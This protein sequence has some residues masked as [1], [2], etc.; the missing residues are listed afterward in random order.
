MS[1][2]KSCLSI[3]I[4]VALTRLL[5]YNGIYNGLR[6]HQGHPVSDP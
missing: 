5:R 3:L 2:W 1:N 6:S 4:Y